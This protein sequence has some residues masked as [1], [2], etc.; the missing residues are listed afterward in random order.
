MG[1][2]F[3][4]GKLDD[5]TAVLE[6]MFIP[7]TPS[8]AYSFVLFLTVLVHLFDRRRNSIRDGKKKCSQ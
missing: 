1:Y 4:G 7:L 8:L 2:A 3:S 6:F 5:I